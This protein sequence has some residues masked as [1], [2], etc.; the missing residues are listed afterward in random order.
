MGHQQTDRRIGSDVGYDRGRC[1]DYS[2]QIRPCDPPIELHTKYS[3]SHITSDGYDSTP[4]SLE[5]NGSSLL[6]VTESE[7]DPSFKDLQLTVD[8]KPSVH[9]DNIIHKK[10]WYLIRV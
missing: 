3:E 1:L 4:V 7:L 9:S 5:F 6:V 10:L 8:N 2:L